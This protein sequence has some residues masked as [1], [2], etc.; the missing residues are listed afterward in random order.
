MAGCTD[1]F[2][3]NYN[4]EA[5]IDDGNCEYYNGEA[6]GEPPSL[7]WNTLISKSC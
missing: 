5:T 4:P 7:I 3:L 6:I 2:G 1:P